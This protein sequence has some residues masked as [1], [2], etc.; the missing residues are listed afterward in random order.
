MKLWLQCRFVPRRE[1]SRGGALS[2]NRSYYG[3]LWCPGGS[4]SSR[5]GLVRKSAI[6]YLGSDV[7]VLPSFSCV[8][9]LVHV[10]AAP[11]ACSAVV[12]PGASR[13]LPEHLEDIVTGS[14]PS[15]GLEGWATLRDILH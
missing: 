4:H 13:T 14:H 7:V 11:M 8:G 9:D 10:S 5:I 2:L 15:L 1:F 3:K 6:S 12:A